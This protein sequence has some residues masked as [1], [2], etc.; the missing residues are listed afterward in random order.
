M[1]S[2]LGSCH[3][4]PNGHVNDVPIAYGALDC[5]L[6]VANRGVWCRL[7]RAQPSCVMTPGPSPRVGSIL[8]ATALLVAMPTND[9]VQRRPRCPCRGQT[10]ATMPHGPLER[11][12]RI[13]RY[14]H[15]AG[16]SW[17]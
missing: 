2:P 12:V 3:S 4:V 16:G 15:V 14:S 5:Y 17:T 11:A 6:D 13:H 8:A 1:L 10:R 7:D 9:Q